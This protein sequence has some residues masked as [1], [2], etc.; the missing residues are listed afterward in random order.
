MAATAPKPG[1]GATADAVRCCRAAAECLHSRSCTKRASTCAPPACAMRPRASAELSAST[2]SAAA[3]R[4][5]ASGEPRAARLMSGRTPPS[6]TSA[7]WFF[8][9]PSASVDSR[10]AAK[11][12]ISSPACCSNLTKAAMPPL[13]TIAALPSCEDT[14]TCRKAKIAWL[15][16]E[17][18]WVRR[19]SRPTPP[20]WTTVAALAGLLFASMPR[21]FAMAP[22]TSMEVVASQAR[23]TK[24]GMP[25]TSTQ[26]A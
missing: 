15:H 5:E 20:V 25:P 10:P 12:Q 3:A 17:G 13:C 7:A 9:L 11:P 22:R 26:A 24:A 2:S 6:A 14:A 23:P 18:S 21:I 1:G 4:R 8:G 19:T 16:A